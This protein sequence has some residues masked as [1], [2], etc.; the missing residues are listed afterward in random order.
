MRSSHAL[1]CVGRVKLYIGAPITTVSAARNSSSVDESA[2]AS[3]VRC[4]SGSLT[5]SRVTTRAPGLVA[6]SWSTIEREIARLALFSPLML[7]SI[8]RMVTIASLVWFCYRGTLNN[9]HRIARKNALICGGR[10]NLWRR[11]SEVTDERPDQPGMPHDQHLALAYRR[12]VDSAGGP[13]A[14]KRFEALQRASP[15][16]PERVAAHADADAAQPRTRWPCQP[17]CHS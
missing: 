1:S 2:K 10:T 15:R 11:N 6:R 9:H 7:L 17:H 14:W 4:G 5:R 12:Q 16:D 8:C 13:D 3:N